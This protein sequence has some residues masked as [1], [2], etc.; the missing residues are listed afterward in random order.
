MSGALAFGEFTLDRANRRVLRA[1][2]PVVLRPKSYSVLEALV[3]H[4]NELVTKQDLRAAVWPD[5]AVSE[6]VLKVCVRELREALGDDPQS[7]RFVETRPR[8]GYRF[9][10]PVRP[11]P[12][13]L[14]RAVPSARPFP[15][16]DQRHSV[17]GRERELA[18]LE[19]L[20]EAARRD[21]VAP[22]LAFVQG[23]AGMG[24]TTLVD[25]LGASKASDPSVL[26][27]FGRCVEHHGPS[28]PLLPFFAGLVACAT[29]DAEVRAVLRTRAPTWCLHMPALFGDDTSLASEALGATR[30]RMLREF[31]DVLREL[32][33]RR[34][35]LWLIE[36]MHW[37]DP[38]S[39]DLL[40]HLASMQRGVAWLGVVTYRPSDIATQGHPLAACVLELEAH[41]HAATITLSAFSADEVTR[42]VKSALGEHVLGATWISQLGERTEGHPLFLASL[43]EYLL[44]VGVLRKDELGRFAAE[45][46]ARDW[47]R[48]VPPDVSSMVTRKLAAL[49]A[50]GRRLLAC[51]SVEG[52]EF[53]ADTLADVVGQDRAEVEERLDELQST[54]RI[55]LAPTE[56]TDERGVPMLSYRFVHALYRDALYAGLAPS[57]RTEIHRRV[58]EVLASRPGGVRETATAALAYHCEAGNQPAAAIEHLMVLATAAEKRVAVA[59]AQAACSRAITLASRLPAAQRAATR[60]RALGMRASLFLATAHFAEAAEDSQQMREAAR[61]IGD[62]RLEIE[63]LMIQ[64][65]QRGYMG[66]FD[67][68]AGAA[69]E[70]LA[71]ATAHER[72]D[73]Q[74]EVFCHAAAGHG[75]GGRMD[76]AVAWLRNALPKLDA[77]TPAKT[78]CIL[79]G[80]FGSMLSLTGGYA[81][82]LPQLDEVLATAREL[83]DA[84]RL[85]GALMWRAHALG[86]LGR[87]GA[88]LQSAD[89]AVRLS[90]QNED[91]MV[92]PR[93]LTITAWLH[94]ELGAY[95]EAIKWDCEAEDAAS[96]WGMV[97]AQCTAQLGLV[98]DHT[99]AGDFASAQ[100]AL[101]A[102]EDTVERRQFV[103][104]LG[105]LRLASVRAR[106]LAQHGDFER[107]EASTRELASLANLHGFQKQAARVQLTLS[108]IALRRGDRQTCK[109]L[110][111]ALLTPKARTTSQLSILVRWQANALMALSCG[112]DDAAGQAAREEV[113]RCWALIQAEVSPRL[114][115]TFRARVETALAF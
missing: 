88:A 95:E 49:D 94:R 110:L 67:G 48:N 75:V 21:E 83:G 2:V 28:E 106:Y 101:R 13:D 25:A 1:G 33:A 97:D 108:E 52:V 16:T 19:R 104:W 11:A 41:R 8:L 17:V 92:L 31:V 68:A 81:E 24:K 37:A 89:E 100:A 59:E 112:V 63:A 114:Q 10:A 72:D 30:A 73:L 115:T 98:L 61:E 34:T 78:K 40:R 5:V 7:P 57:R 86:N 60:A 39:I 105:R 70:A 87:F 91:G 27:F 42:Y 3:T 56:A 111:E 93:A 23:E 18:E 46:S 22:R 47:L 26:W 96:R 38:S 4:A 99:C 15:V 103:A 62:A 6:T 84:L 113:E 9:V 14:G 53:Q 29:E 90:R 43:L 12:I 109:Q 32:G 82:A 77:R 80:D 51:A 74:N 58:A 35:V 71:V 55:L 45:T 107:A 66:D 64:Y 69:Q 65:R 85:G 54:H 76:E 79:A 36:D 50:K 102:C 44:V 20:L